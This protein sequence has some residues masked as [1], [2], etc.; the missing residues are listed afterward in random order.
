MREEREDGSIARQWCTLHDCHQDD[1]EHSYDYWA[2]TL[3]GS[4]AVEDALVLQVI[5][6]R[7]RG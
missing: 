3:R 7:R 6:A 5:N 4:S 1:P 2:C